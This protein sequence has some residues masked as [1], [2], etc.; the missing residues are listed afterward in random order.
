MY[1][2]YGSNTGTSESFAQ[3]VAD[4]AAK[5]GFRAT[6]GTL[7]S[8][9]DHLPADG[10]VVI[11]CASFEGEPADNAAH[12]VSWLLSVKGQ[13]LPNLRYA[14]F[15]CGNKDWARTYQRIPKLIDAQFEEHGGKRLIERG[16]GDAGSADFFEAFDDWEAKLWHVLPKEYGTVVTKNL[17]A[18]L[19]VQT[20][21]K[22]TERAIDLRQHDAALGTV[23]E[24]RVL[25]APGV[26]EKR[27]IEFELPA[28]MTT[29]AGDYLAILPS[30]PLR[31]VHRAISR[32][33]LL[34]EQQIMLSSSGPSSLPVGKAITVLSLLS[35]YVELSQPATTR[36]LRA[37]AD[38]ESSEKTRNALQALQSSHTEQVMAK[39]LS[40]LDI[41]EEYPD[42]KLTFAGFLSMLPS[43]R[44]RQY[45]ISS[46]PLWNAE[47][48][49]LTVS[50]L[51]TVPISGRKEPFLGVAS[52]FLA[53][54]RPGDKV[55]MAVRASNVA[56]HL[57]QDPKT[58][59]VLFCAGSGLAPMRGFLQER[60]LQ[61]KA[62]REVGTAFLFFGCR[63]PR[64]D[65]LY[66]DSD[67]KEWEELGIVNLRPAFSRATEESAGCKYVQDRLWHAR[68]EINGL[69]EEGAKYYV[70]G[71]G[72]VA[73]AIKDTLTAIIQEQRKVSADEAA[74]MFERAT[75]GRF[76]TDIFE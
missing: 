33:G 22:S 71:S 50:V 30:N 67:L 38:V 45:S 37:L 57:P 9:A 25:T 5:Y 58:P 49:T 60:A 64:E 76:A 20:V 2:L 73:H 24:N 55:Q 14:V 16:E 7:D 52:T 74:A 36:D 34:A 19:E 6:I 28:G 44:V 26:P 61:K 3:R 32:F 69:Y 63:N 27:H 39:R 43:M 56:F 62:G 35:G 59:L 29:R 15:G 12:F 23:V 31:D 11:V 8:V 65:Y 17:S 40:L 42:V 51:N 1:V 70:C 47:R 68:H 54:L 46:S 18:T 13:E 48:V 53:S 21:S 72:K 66:S 10:P 4:S 75:V 41:L